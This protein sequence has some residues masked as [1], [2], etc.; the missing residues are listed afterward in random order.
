MHK[1]DWRCHYSYGLDWTDRIEQN[2]YRKLLGSRT[3][4]AFDFI[5]V[6][7]AKSKRGKP[8]AGLYIMDM[9]TEVH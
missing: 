6:Y 5:T 8:I 3:T 7:V 2:Y 4:T 1:L 9:P